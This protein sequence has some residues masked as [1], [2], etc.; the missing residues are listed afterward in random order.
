MKR[1]SIFGQKPWIIPLGKCLFLAPFKTLTFWSKI[2]L[3]CQEY[4]KKSVFVWVDNTKKIQ[5]KKVR[6]LDKNHG[7]TPQKNVV[8]GTL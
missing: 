6:L 5:M 3:V 8:F 4:R 2:I 7:L 1:N